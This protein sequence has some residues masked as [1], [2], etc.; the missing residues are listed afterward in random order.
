[1][2]EIV[3]WVA[4]GEIDGGEAEKV[5]PPQ[6]GQTRMVAMSEAPHPAQNEF[7]M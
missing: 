5:F 3:V 4:A 1:V 2:G 6:D 7:A